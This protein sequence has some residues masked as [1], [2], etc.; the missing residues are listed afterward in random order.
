MRMDDNTPRIGFFVLNPPGIIGDQ[1]RFVVPGRYPL[2][3][4]PVTGKGIP[5]PEHALLHRRF[6]AP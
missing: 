1:G 4:D 5:V 2:G 3:M 6:T